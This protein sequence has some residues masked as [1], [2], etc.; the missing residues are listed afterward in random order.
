M[1]GED[2]VCPDPADDAG[3]TTGALARRLGVSPTTVRTWDRRYGLGPADREDGR[4]RRWRT[5]DIAA[6]EEMCRL[7]AAGVAP[8]EAARAAR[9]GAG[10]G[11]TGALPGRGAPSTPGDGS[12]TAGSAP[13]T[14]GFAA[15]TPG[16]PLSTPATATAP[17]ADIPSQSR[18]P[19]SPSPT[20]GVPSQAPGGARAGGSGLPLGD[21]R[22]EARGVARA[23]VRLDSPAVQQLLN[24]FVRDHGVVAAWEDVMMP[25]LHAVGR[26]WQSSGDRYVEVEH[27]LSWHVS[28]ALRS[29]PLLRPCPR[30]PS[31]AAP[32]LLAC[33]PD[34]QHTLPIEAL[35]AALRERGTPTRMLGAA[36]PVRALTAAVRRTGPGAVVLWSQ[37]RS[38]AS[39]PLARHLADTRWGVKGARLGPVV[40]AAGPG[41]GH[42]APPGLLRPRELAEALAMLSRAEARTIHAGRSDE[43]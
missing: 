39:S 9:T 40:L 15:P 25:T 10:R 20:P 13:P 35:D 16:L 37:T 6:L 19:G 12:S 23:S 27:L 26:K 33:L 11:R 2:G 22:H 17:T 32:V 14:D 34:E 42:R 29:T 30:P 38:T 5:A 18:P 36:V 3:V 43:H 24:T 8:A 21:V 31:E 7:T 1:N 28:T 41:W 4:H